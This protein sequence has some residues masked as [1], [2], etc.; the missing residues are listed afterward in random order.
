[1]AEG[2]AEGALL[3]ADQALELKKSARG[4]LARA[5]AL[6]AMGRIEDALAAIDR[7]IALS[8]G[9]AEGWLGRGRVLDMLKRTGEARA[10]FARYL[11]LQ[12]TG[13]TADE[14]RKRLAQ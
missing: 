13:A 2:N 5:Q 1:M 7:S 4:H 9:F 14:I 3:Y 6:Q 8:D 12:P 11:E 10:A